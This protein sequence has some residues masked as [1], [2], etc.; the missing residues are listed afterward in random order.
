MSMGWPCMNITVKKLFQLKYKA[1]TEVVTLKYLKMKL[2]SWK[3]MTHMW[4]IQC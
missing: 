3:E 1:I 4:W 2:V